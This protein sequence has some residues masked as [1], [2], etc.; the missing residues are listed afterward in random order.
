MRAGSGVLTKGGRGYR[1]KNWFVT[2][3]MSHVADVGL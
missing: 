1:G 2:W 3:A